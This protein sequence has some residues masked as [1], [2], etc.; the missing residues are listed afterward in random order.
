MKWR[1]FIASCE[2]PK[3]K[4]CTWSYGVIGNWED[5][6]YV[7]LG[8]NINGVYFYGK[9]GNSIHERVSVFH[10][11]WSS[12]YWYYIK[13]ELSMD[14]LVFTWYNIGRLAGCGVKH[15][16]LSY[17]LSIALIIGLSIFYIILYVDLLVELPFTHFSF[18]ITL[19]LGLP[20]SKATNW[21]VSH[22]IP[23]GSL[24]TLYYYFI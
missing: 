1:K 4:L 21:L 2:W 13:H 23:M 14:I 12:I 18:L 22:E 6:F 11:L 16:Q 7:Q 15:L 19:S 17:Y 20:V 9:V 24:L 8:S 3:S 5:F 10:F